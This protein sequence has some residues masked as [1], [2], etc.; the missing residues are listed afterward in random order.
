MLMPTGG[1]SDKVMVNES[2]LSAKIIYDNLDSHAAMTS[3]VSY[4]CVSAGKETVDGFHESL[5]DGDDELHY[6]IYDN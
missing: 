4:G 5:L 2:A 6:V 3:N 1:E